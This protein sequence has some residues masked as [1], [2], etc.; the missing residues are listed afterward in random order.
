MSETPHLVLSRGLFTT[1]MQQP[2]SELSTSTMNP[3]PG[4]SFSHVEETKTATDTTDEWPDLTGGTI[5]SES[6]FLPSISQQPLGNITAA[7]MN[8]NQN[9]EPNLQ[10]ELSFPSLG[11]VPISTSSSDQTWPFALDTVANPP[12]S[13]ESKLLKFAVAA[14]NSSNASSYSGSISSRPIPADYPSMPPQMGV[15]DF[16][17][18]NFPPMMTSVP[19]NIEGTGV[20]GGANQNDFSTK[21][22]TPST[23]SSIRRSMQ[24]QLIERVRKLLDYDKD[25]FTYF[26]TLMGW[27]KNG[28]ITVEEFK[29]RCLGLFG[30][31]QWIEIGP[32]LAEMMPNPEKKNELL[33]SFGV[34]SGVAKG[35]TSTIISSAKSR[36]RVP[37][38]VPSVWGTGP[39]APVRTSNYNSMSSAR[40]SHEEYPTLGSA[41]HQP[42]PIP[43]PTPW[44][45]VIQ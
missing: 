16:S 35:V 13:E 30:S 19:M 38:C 6:M 14:T 24:S 12:R 25:K 8:A 11:S 4:F 34:R 20:L 40:L 23:D 39:V 28:E 17:S 31:N 22:T 41:V 7:V 15:L 45:V 33:S 27:Y 5:P 42:K 37:A 18:Q 2:R 10:S 44:N 32:D 21:S 36:K 26:K 43:Q 29:A 9:Q 3:P 1:N